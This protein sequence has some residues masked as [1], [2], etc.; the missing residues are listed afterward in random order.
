[1]AKSSKIIF[2]T[3]TLSSYKQKLSHFKPQ[4]ITN[5]KEASILI[6]LC[7]VN[8]EAHILFTVR[9]TKL[10]KHSGEVSF[11]G[12]NRDLD[13]ESLIATALRETE[14]EIFVDQ[15]TIKIL[16]EFIAVPDKTN[17]KTVT[18]IVG[19]LGELDPP[20]MEF[21]TDEVQEIFSVSINQL[22]ETKELENFRGTGFIMPSW[23]VGSNRIWGL[24]GY[25][26]GQYLKLIV[27]TENE[28]KSRL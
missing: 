8:N 7:T 14:E 9:S 27:Q 26:L 2:D 13:D 22:I 18:S 12:G 15:K 16:G 21:N 20:K 19:Y 4:K 11:P 3:A 23:I 24:T 17:T 6:P 25:I 1:M 5:T 28:T 10:R